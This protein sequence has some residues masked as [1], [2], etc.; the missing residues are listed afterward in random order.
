MIERGLTKSI[1]ELLDKWNE[2]LVYLESCKKPHECDDYLQGE[3]QY[4]TYCI[5]E[6][7]EVLKNE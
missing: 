5:N 3:I 1:K 7:T 2:D 4:L 6:L